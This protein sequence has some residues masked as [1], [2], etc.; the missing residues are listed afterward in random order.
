MIKTCPKCDH[1]N[2]N[3]TGAADE[4]CPNCGVIYAKAQPPLPRGRVTPSP[5]TY[6][7][8]ARPSDFQPSRP[9]ASRLARA[10]DGDPRAG[11]VADMRQGSLYP[12]FR[13]LTQVAYVVGMV[14]AVLLLLAALVQLFTGSFLAGAVGA[15]VGA[16]V[17]V[18]VMVGRELALML[19]DLSDA[20]VRVAASQRRAAA[21]GD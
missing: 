13:R 8:G 20:M 17:L 2:R 12:A 4:E 14:L 10:E 1:V 3:A 18:A 5:I 19:A 15:G 9:A 6:P 7:A 11:F 21:G 16:A